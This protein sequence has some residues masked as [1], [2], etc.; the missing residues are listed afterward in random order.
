MSYEGLFSGYGLL[1]RATGL[2]FNSTAD[3][4]IRICSGLYRVAQILVI[5]ASANL[6]LSAA[7]GGLYTATSKG[8]T[9]I[10]SALQ[11]YATLSASSK[12]LGLTLATILTTDIRTERTLYFSLSSAHGSAATADIYIYGNKFDT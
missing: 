11:G 4:P 8:G 7:A 10:V 6:A 9:A 5:N 1:G 2:N 12:I 3:Q